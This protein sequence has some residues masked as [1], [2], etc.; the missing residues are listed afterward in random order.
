MSLSGL[1]GDPFQDADIFVPGPELVPQG[2]PDQW[3]VPNEVFTERVK[4]DQ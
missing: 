3:V 2:S 4:T 1:K